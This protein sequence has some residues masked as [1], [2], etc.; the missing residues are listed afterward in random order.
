VRAQWIDVGA[1]DKVR[2]DRTFCA[3]VEGFP[4]VIARCGNEFYAMEDRCTHDGESF[5]AA[6]VEEC[7][8]ICPRHFARFCLKTGEALSPPAYEP[9]RTFKVRIENGRILVES[10]VD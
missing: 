6:D 7:E 9:A 10:P 1:A 8:I 4:V 5:A 2:E 3:E